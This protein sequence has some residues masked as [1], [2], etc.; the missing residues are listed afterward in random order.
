MSDIKDFDIVI[1]KTSY[2]SDNN[3]LNSGFILPE[4]NDMCFTSIN[5]FSF[6]TTEPSSYQ[7]L[8]GH[9]ERENIY[10]SA[11]RNLI[12]QKKYL[13]LVYELSN[14]YISEEEFHNELDSKEDEYLIKVEHN[15][16]SHSKI[17][18]FINVLSKI[19]VDFEEDDLLEIFS[20]MGSNMDSNFLSLKYSK[21]ILNDKTRP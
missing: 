8:I 1:S 10:I 3:Y 16:L 18:S 2:S 13:S 12:K 19:D 9:I 4:E 5:S 6:N 21:C 11:I 7:L 17:D 14:D 15:H 20:I